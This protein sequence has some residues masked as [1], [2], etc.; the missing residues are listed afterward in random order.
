[1]PAESRIQIFLNAVRARLDRVRL[2]KMVS[3]A[4][5]IT[6]FLLAAWCLLWVLQG[7]SVPRIGYVVAAIGFPLLTGLAW[8]LGR[9]DE[10]QA[11]RFADDHFGLKDALSSHLGF[12][13]QQREGEFIALQVEDTARRVA[14][15]Q[16]ATI[17]V[18]WSRK[19]LTIGGI[20]L[21]SS[22][23][24]GFKKPSP[25][26]MERLSLEQETSR[27]T[28]EINQE[29]EKEIEQLL[30]QTPD[31]EKELLNP[32]EWRQWLKELRETKDQKEAMRQYAELE[33]RITEAAQKLS[34]R[35]QEQLLAKAAEELQQEAP[36]RPMA[37]A[38]E[39]KDYKQAAEQLRQM[40]PQ[41]EG[42][43]PEEARQQM[44][45]LKS[46]AQR[47]AAAARNYQ[48]RSGQQSQQKTGSE[49]QSAAGANSSKSGQ[50]SQQAQGSQG[51]PGKE[52]MDEQMIALEQ[53][54]NQL[55]Q[56]MQKDPSSSECKNCQSQ[57]QQQI[58]KLSQSLCKSAAQ[59]NAAKKLSS[60][61]QCA[62]KCQGYLGNKECNSLSQCLGEKP[63]GKKAGMGSSENR[64]DESEITQD[65]GN[66]DQL[67]GQKGTGPSSTSIESA[68]SGSGAASRRAN[69]SERAWQR[70]VESFVQREDVPAEVKSGVKEYFKAIQQVGEEQPSK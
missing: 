18:R 9:D 62:S 39:Q 55:D 30:T 34:L 52:S 32:D 70:Q 1:M 22:L 29:L 63:S 68:D 14:S 21:L 59:C 37:K 24:M 60:L 31:D 49:S 53:Q 54:V 35:S 36:L 28:E 5:L 66:R 56:Q 44:A 45:K 15:C 41:A 48:Q 10:R 67:Q 13:E 27:K 26:V 16:P 7:Y 65:N 46:A 42:Q 69:E 17:P 8:W 20:L 40:Q 12:S 58:S 57:V 4:L 23:V 25:I 43:K 19:L 33:R 6:G 50:S 51:N 64:R 3:L 47:M 11:A 61:S 2:A 38:L